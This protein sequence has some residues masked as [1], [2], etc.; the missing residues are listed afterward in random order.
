MTNLRMSDIIRDVDVH[1]TKLLGHSPLDILCH[2][3]GLPQL[4]GKH[5]EP[6]HSNLPPIHYE[7]R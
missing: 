7:P 4:V 1:D 6:K 2:A 3:V 5:K